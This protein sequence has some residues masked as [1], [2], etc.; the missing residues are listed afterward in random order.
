MKILF[1]V[2]N[3]VKDLLNNIM[4]FFGKQKQTVTEV[5]PVKRKYTKKKSSSKRKKT[6]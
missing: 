4:S 1:V 2:G 5:K 3:L 6:R